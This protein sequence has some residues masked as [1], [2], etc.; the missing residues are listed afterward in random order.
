ME[1]N[2]EARGLRIQFDIKHCNLNSHELAKMEG[3]V[4]HLTRVTRSFPVA[5]L[6]ILVRQHARTNNYH[7]KTT[8]VLSGRTL[9]TG[10]R[11]VAVYPA[12]ERCI[13][14]LVKKV[15]AYKRY[16]SNQVE[17]AKQEKGT[18]KQVEPTHDPDPQLL[19]QAVQNADYA[20]FR[21]ALLGYEEPLRKRIGRWIQRYPD[22]EAQ[23]GKE[24]TLEDF[25]EEVFLNAFE[26]YE[27]RPLGLSLSEWL[28]A[29]IDPSVR[30]LADHPEEEK[31]N[32]I[33]AR[34]WVE[35]PPRPQ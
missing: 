25:V 3:A 17:V 19:Q 15:E 30:A 16:L 31:L 8:L 22:I 35:S 29:L 11:D 33:F 23:L 21:Q 28:E 34:T 18:H 14:K 32:I 1:R 12:Y 20:G 27:H 24:L 26:R 7:V 13:R 4:E 6:H 2:H 9:F 5:D 10:D